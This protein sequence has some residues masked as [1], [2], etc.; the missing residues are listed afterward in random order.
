MSENG[1]YTEVQANLFRRAEFWN[2]SFRF[3]VLLKVDS[4]GC[5]KKI[6]PIHPAQHVKESANQAVNSFEIPTYKAFLA[7]H[8]FS[9]MEIGGI[10]AL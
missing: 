2:S 6:S 5:P 1:S 10:V 3:T 9:C 7:V 4:T 8:C